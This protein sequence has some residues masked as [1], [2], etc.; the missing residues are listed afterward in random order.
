MNRPT[1]RCCGNVMYV[2]SVN[3]RASDYGD[4]RLEVVERGVT[5][6]ENDPKAST[7][8]GQR[9][10]RCSVSSFSF[11]TFFFSAVSARYRAPIMPELAI[12][13]RSPNHGTHA[14]RRST[15]Q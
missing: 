14:L 7:A 12:V 1:T 6:Q 5:S 4:M 11:I 13:T 10:V 3:K 8:G 2:C 15:L 9:F